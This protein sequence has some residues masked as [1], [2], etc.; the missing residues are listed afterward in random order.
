MST[1]VPTTSPSSSMRRALPALLLLLAVYIALPWLMGVLQPWVPADTLA[2]AGQA[3]EVAIGLVLGLWVFTFIRHERRLGERHR[4]EIEQ[5][6]QADA[7]TGLGNRRAYVRELEL[8]LNRSRRTH[9]PVAVLYMDVDAMGLLNARHGRT[10]GDQTLRMLGAVLRSSARFGI[11][12]GYRVG[13]DE[14][15]LVLGASR[16]GAESVRRRL[17]WNFHDRSPRSSQLRMGLSTWD[18]RANPAELLEQAKRALEG[19]RHGELTA[20]LA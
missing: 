10:I 5:L 1:D 11:D 3:A 8:L 2:L 18:G 4:R 17:E 9:E 15:A 19:A 12:A 14:F 16:E 13:E 7:L 20:Q 6:T